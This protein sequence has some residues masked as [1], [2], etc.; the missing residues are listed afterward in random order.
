M[1]VE[2]D[3]L[4]KFVGLVGIGALGNFEAK[5]ED[6]VLEASV[7]SAHNAVLITAKLPVSIDDGEE[8]KIYANADINSKVTE[9]Y[10][11]RFSYETDGIE[12]EGLMMPL[13]DVEER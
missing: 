13:R 1:I 12:V 7:V 8:V 11:V 4:K 5:V 2:S 6:G 10:P 3:K 9:D